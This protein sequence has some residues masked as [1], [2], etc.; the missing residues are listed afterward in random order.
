MRI[1]RT[2]SSTVRR[3]IA[4]LSVLALCACATHD[5]NDVGST[6]SFSKFF[7]V[8]QKN[9]GRVA[10]VPKAIDYLLNCCKSKK[11]AIE[12]LQ[13]DGF[14]IDRKITRQNNSEFFAGTHARELKIQSE[15]DEMIS[16]VKKP[17]SL[18]HKQIYVIDLH[19]Q[20]GFVVRG[21]ALKQDRYAPL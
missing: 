18:F 16:L 6:S 19:L 13:N 14:E 4:L 5:S 15:D 11:V 21:E 20:H 9:N 2:K 10:Q 3:P 7:Y 8:A 17:Y 12:F 1:P